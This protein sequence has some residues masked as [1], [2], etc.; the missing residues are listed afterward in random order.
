VTQFE[1]IATEALNQ[2]RE[3]HPPGW[4]GVEMHGNLIAIGAV[5]HQNSRLWGDRSAMA[6]DMAERMRRGGM[7][8]L[9][10]AWRGTSWALV[11]DQAED[12]VPLGSIVGQIQ[13]VVRTRQH[14]QFGRPLGPV[15]GVTPTPAKKRK[16]RKLLTDRL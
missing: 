13:D 10:F 16:Q 1:Q 11:L 8:A 2:F 7:A 14:E 15:E 3:A 5:D 12:P 6:R 4:V 9:G